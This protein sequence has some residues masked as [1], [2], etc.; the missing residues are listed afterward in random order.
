ME[1][2][3]ILSEE[4]VRNLSPEQQNEYNHF[5]GTVRDSGI[6]YQA[7]LQKFDEILQQQY[8]SGVLFSPN[9]LERYTEILAK[10]VN[11]VIDTITQVRNNVIN[12]KRVFEQFGFQRIDEGLDVLKKFVETKLQS[13]HYQNSLGHQD[14]EAV[15]PRI[16][17]LKSQITQDMSFYQG[18]YD[19]KISAIADYRRKKEAYDRLSLFGKLAARINGKK[20]ELTEAQQKNVYY[21]SARI[22]SGTQQPGDIVNPYQYDEYLERQQPEQ[23]TGGMRR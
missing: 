18:Y 4:D 23:S 14:L 9:S 15:L 22:S 7:Q 8:R 17:Q 1:Q 11:S 16:D 10:N 6:V 21:N 2:K 12:G 3:Y 20:K 5:L 13:P 19:E